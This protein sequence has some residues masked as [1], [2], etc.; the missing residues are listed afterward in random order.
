MITAPVE[1]SVGMTIPRH[2]LVPL[3]PRSCKAMGQKA[4]VSL[5]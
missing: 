2:R 4:I 5:A 3:L 1:L